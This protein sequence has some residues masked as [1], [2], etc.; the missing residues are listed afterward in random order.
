MCAVTN[1]N[2]S[3]DPALIAAWIVAKRG[4]DSNP[5]REV[6]KTPALPAELPLQMLLAFEYSG[7]V[8]AFPAQSVSADL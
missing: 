8:R 3:D 1:P 2:L 4:R 5:R 7:V 6:F